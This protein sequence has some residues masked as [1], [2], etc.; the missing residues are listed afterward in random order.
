M[1]NATQ[2]GH[3][4][5]ARIL[6]DRE[7]IAGRIAEL[8]R[9]IEKDYEGRSPVLVGILKGS[10]PFLADLMR[11]LRIDTTMDLISLSSYEGD[12]STG[13][14]RVLLDLRESVEG[15]DVIVVEDIVDTGLTLSYL[16]KNFETRKPASLSLCTLLDKPDC[17]K[18]DVQPE[19]SGFKI[20]NEFVVGYGLDYDERYRDLPFIGVLKEEAVKAGRAE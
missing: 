4:D 8:A 18:V 11:E 19:Y 15:K 5:I 20:P 13:V 3:P 12:R 17:R 14:V 1:E 7:K 2:T 16:K 6:I 10:V 9:T